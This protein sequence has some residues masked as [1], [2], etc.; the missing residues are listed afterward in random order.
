MP[1]GLLDPWG[2]LWPLFPLL[3]HARETLPGLLMFW[4]ES[5]D[6]CMDVQPHGDRSCS[7]RSP[8][9]PESCQLTVK[10]DEQVQLVPAW[11]GPGCP[12]HPGFLLLPAASMEGQV[13]GMAARQE[14]EGASLGH[15]LPGPS[16]C[17][18]L[19]H[20]PCPQLP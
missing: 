16:R 18:Q 2:L 6:P 13:P 12:I 10:C 9:R 3:H 5:Q 19:P 8:A 14:Q 1:R 15:V 7:P 17:W 20:P 11:G 4:P